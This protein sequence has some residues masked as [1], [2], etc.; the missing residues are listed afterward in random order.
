MSEVTRSR[1]STVPTVLRAVHDTFTSPTTG[2][3]SGEVT[4]NERRNS[5]Y[6]ELPLRPDPAGFPYGADQ[7][8]Q[9]ASTGVTFP[10]RVETDVVASGPWLTRM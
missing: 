3:W 2:V 9:V 5:R 10:V 7:F 6:R 1:V 4:A 8:V